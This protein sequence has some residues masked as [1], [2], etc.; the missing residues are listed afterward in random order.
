MKKI[1]IGIIVFIVLIAFAAPYFMKFIINSD[2]QSAI[3][4]Y[5]WISEAKSQISSKYN[6]ANNYPDI[7]VDTNKTTNKMNVVVYFPTNHLEGS[8]SKNPDEV[9]LH[10]DEVLGSASIV[11]GLVPDKTQYSVTIKT[12]QYLDAALKEKYN[13]RAMTDESPFNCS[14]I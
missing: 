12:I 4:Q 6:L 8:I 5:P 13:N 9:T 11:C 10:K 1:I 2:Q 3:K 14:E 7:S